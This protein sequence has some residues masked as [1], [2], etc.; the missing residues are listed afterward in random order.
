M[1]A[2]EEVWDLP[3]AMHRRSMPASRP[4]SVCVQ[5]SLRCSSCLSECSLLMYK[6]ESAACRQLETYLVC[7][8]ECANERSTV[9]GHGKP[10][11]QAAKK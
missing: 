2:W 3:F 7:I 8:A 11:H 6:T 9:G 1:S 10:S 4:S 5:Q